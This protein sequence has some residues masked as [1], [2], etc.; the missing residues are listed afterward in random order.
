MLRN[1]GVWSRQNPGCSDPRDFRIAKLLLLGK[2]R[3]F[4]GGINESSCSKIMNRREKDLKRAGRRH[5]ARH[6]ASI[7]LLLMVT[8]MHGVLEE[9]TRKV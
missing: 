4:Q 3:F 2:S 1:I 7:T 6:L 9:I 5:L 8:M